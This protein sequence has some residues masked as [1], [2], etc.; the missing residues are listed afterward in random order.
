M[1][2]DHIEIEFQTEEGTK[3]ICKTFDIDEDT[4]NKKDF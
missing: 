3:R 4:L 2:I 1:V